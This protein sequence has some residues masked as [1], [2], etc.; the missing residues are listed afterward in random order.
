MYIS[1]TKKFLIKRDG[2]V[3]RQNLGEVSNAKLAEAQDNP[4]QWIL[5]NGEE[6]NV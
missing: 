5:I 4:D 3:H 6:K 1:L 2:R